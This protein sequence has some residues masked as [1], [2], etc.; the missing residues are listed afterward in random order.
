VDQDPCLYHHSTPP[1]TQHP[2]V[3]KSVQMVWPLS[4]LITQPVTLLL[5]H[6][7]KSTPSDPTSP[8]LVSVLASYKL[9][10]TAPLLEI[11]PRALQ[12]QIPMEPLLALMTIQLALAQTLIQLVHQVDLVLMLLLNAYRLVF[13]M[14]W[15]QSEMPTSTVSSSSMLL[16]DKN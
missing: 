14:L 6:S 13:M 7:T 9:N 2:Q 16:K 15:P 4:A 1:T 10:R 5:C 8:K 12:D 11:T 3:A